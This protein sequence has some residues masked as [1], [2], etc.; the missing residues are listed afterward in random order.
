MSSAQ[1][2]TGTSLPLPYLTWLHSGTLQNK[3]RN[4]AK[5]I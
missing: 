1:L 3:L 5:Y 4:N 2:S